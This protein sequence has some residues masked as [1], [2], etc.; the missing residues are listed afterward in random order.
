MR[1][2]P[3]PP[4]EIASLGVAIKTL[5]QVFDRDF[6]EVGHVGLHC[7]K[8]YFSQKYRAVKIYISGGNGI[9]RVCPVIGIPKAAGQVFLRDRARRVAWALGERSFMAARLALPGSLR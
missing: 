4:C 5:V 1:Q 6:D 3:L 8:P 9:G 7:W 2:R